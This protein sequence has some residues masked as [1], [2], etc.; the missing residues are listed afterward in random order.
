MLSQ[1]S[2]IAESSRCGAINY[3]L[4]SVVLNPLLPLPSMLAHSAAPLREDVDIDKA[5]CCSTCFAGSVQSVQGTLDESISS[6]SSA[7]RHVLMGR[8]LNAEQLDNFITSPP[9]QALWEGSE[10]L[11]GK[12][13]LSLTFLIAPSDEQA[14]TGISSGFLP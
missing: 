3:H 11:P 5:A 14:S 12:V 4:S 7:S 1:L 2:G 9:Y 6:T 13:A 10:R 8:F